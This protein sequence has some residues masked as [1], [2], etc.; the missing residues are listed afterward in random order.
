MIPTNTNE[1]NK[2]HKAYMDDIDAIRI[3]GRR[4]PPQTSNYMIILKYL[5]KDSQHD[6]K[7]NEWLEKEE[8]EENCRENMNTFV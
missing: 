7:L 1:S 4:R 8:T 3:L 2:T 6:S 5:R